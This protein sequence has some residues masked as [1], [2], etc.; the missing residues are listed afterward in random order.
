MR[1][2]EAK[3]L[4]HH[5]REDDMGPSILADFRSLDEWKALLCASR[6]T[7]STVTLEQQ[8]VGCSTDPDGHSSGMFVYEYCHGPGYHR[9]VDT[10][11]PAF[12][13][14]AAWPHLRSI[15]LFSFERDNATSRDTPFWRSDIT[16]VD[17][18]NSSKA[19]FRTSKSIR[20]WAVGCYW[21]P[22]V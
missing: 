2:S 19:G 15:Q 21:T 3:D 1:P 11:L 20:S 6:R 16:G 9:F 17:L 4:T 14:D 5:Y 12:L 7:L 18:V 13:E 8:P 10:V 22:R